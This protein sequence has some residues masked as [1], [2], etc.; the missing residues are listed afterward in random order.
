MST[1]VAFSGVEALEARIGS[2]VA[3]TGFV[4]LEQSLIDAFARLTGDHQWIHVDPARAGAES[5]FGRTIA[6]GFLTLSLL[7][8]FLED[9]VRYEPARL[10]VSC[11]L[12]AVRFMSP[13]PAGAAVR[14]RVRLR[15]VTRAGDAVEATWRFTIEVDGERLP[16]AVADWTVRYVP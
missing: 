11:G 5:P 8:R 16:S 3:V 13:V 1:A 6:H 14:A 15:A 7:A 4:R 2:E 10:V 12:N 9:A